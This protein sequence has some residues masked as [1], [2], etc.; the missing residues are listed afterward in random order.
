MQLVSTV[1]RVTKLLRKFGMCNKYRTENYT[2]NEGYFVS[3]RAERRSGSS[4]S[5]LR[6]PERR[7]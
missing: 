6:K 4:F 5:E 7:S 1:Y 2:Y 3:K